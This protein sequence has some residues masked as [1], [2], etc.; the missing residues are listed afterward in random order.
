M[1]TDVDTLFLDGHGLTDDHTRE[2][3]GFFYRPWRWEAVALLGV[4]LLV[5]HRRLR[6]MLV[7]MLFISGLALSFSLL[8]VMLAYPVIHVMGDVFV[9][10]ALF[11]YTSCAWGIVAVSER[12]GG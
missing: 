9:A 12:V 2:V 11:F 3:K 4:G 7:P 1:P 8:P 5:S 6:G 10:G